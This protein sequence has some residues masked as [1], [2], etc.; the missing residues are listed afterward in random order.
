MTSTPE[1]TIRPSTRRGVWIF[2]IVLAAMT[3]GLNLLILVHKPELWPRAAA[4]GLVPVGLILIA[5][6]RLLPAS[7]PNAKRI[8]FILAYVFALAGLVLVSIDYFQ[9]ISAS[10]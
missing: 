7:S 8:L 1:P 3:L 2:V 5:W 6:S 9:T 10:P 4:R